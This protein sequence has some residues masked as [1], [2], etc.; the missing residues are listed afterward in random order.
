LNYPIKTITQLETN[1]ADV[2]LRELMK[3]PRK[4]F[5]KVKAIS[6]FNLILLQNARGDAQKRGITVN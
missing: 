6:Q 1:Y 3:Y 2:L 5:Y 4:D